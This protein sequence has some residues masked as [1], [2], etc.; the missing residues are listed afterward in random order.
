[1]NATKKPTDQEL[2]NAL[3]SVYFMTSVFYSVFSI[4]ESRNR[5]Y[6]EGKFHANRLIEFLGKEYMKIGKNIDFRGSESST[7]EQ[8][9]ALDFYKAQTEKKFEVFFRDAVVEG[10]VNRVELFAAINT[11]ANQIG[12]NQV[13]SM[14]GITTTEKADRHFVKRVEISNKI[15]DVPENVL[16]NIL[17]SIKRYEQ[18]SISSDSPE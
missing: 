10:G 6:R 8:K 7:K 18:K 3:T 13:A 1:M 14:L 9:E 17:R 15:L 11:I 2:E 16:N 4:L 12:N 5:V